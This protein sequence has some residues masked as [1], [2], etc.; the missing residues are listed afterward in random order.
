MGLDDW[1]VESIERFR[2]LGPRQALYS[3]YSELLMGFLRRAGRFVEYG[4]SIHDHEWDLLIVLDACRVDAVEQI[5]SDYPFLDDGAVYS[6]ASTS[7][8]WVEKNLVR[9]DT[10]DL[11]YVTANPNAERLDPDELAV[12]DHVWKYGHDDDY[13][14]TL[15]GTVTDAAIRAHRRHRP[16]RLVVHYMQPH[17]P[18]RGLDH[19][20]SLWKALRDGEYDPSE[21]WPAYV[22]TLEWVLESVEVLLENVDADTAVITA[23]H[24]ELMGEWN[25]YGHGEFIPV[26]TLKRVPWCVT[27]ATDEGTRDPSDRTRE[28]DTSREEQLEQLGY[29]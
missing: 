9:P 7:W 25:L 18:L 24:A 8:E 26:P 3:S 10:S 17:L 4:D 19:P 5:E 12:L 11:G 15:P 16:D 29:V 22:D 6:N 13:G 23:D 20:N 14:S 21:T 2:S 28:I 27:S 1:V